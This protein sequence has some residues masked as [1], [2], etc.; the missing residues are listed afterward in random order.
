MHSDRSSI[1]AIYQ[2]FFKVK[3]VSPILSISK[4][5]AMS[6]ALED[7]LGCSELYFLTWEK[8]YSS[9]IQEDRLLIS[10][11]KA[12]QYI[13]HTSGRYIS[14]SL[15]SSADVRAYYRV[16]IFEMARKNR[17]FPHFNGPGS[18]VGGW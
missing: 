15:N 8:L 16:W 6:C 5:M 13:F 4:F 18:S 11:P 2:K 10:D 1:Q 3:L 7:R 14:R 9:D 17:D 12:L